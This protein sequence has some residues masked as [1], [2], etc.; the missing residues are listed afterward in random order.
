MKIPKLKTTFS[1]YTDADL[2][3]LAGHVLTS[4]TGNASFPDPIP[5][6]TDLAA[7]ITEYKESLIKAAAL[8][9]LNI[10]DK[11]EKRQVLETLLTQLSFYVIYVAMG[12]VAILTSSGF[13]LTKERETSSLDSPGRID[14]LQGKSTGEL[15]VMTR[16]AVK[17]AVSY[18][19]EYADEPVTESTRWNYV[20]SSRSKYTLQGLTAGKLYFVRV[21]AVGRDAS[22]TYSPVSSSYVL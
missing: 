10:A 7:A 2:E 16:E 5:E 1:R 12:N 4:M 14:L 3:V 21:G 9:R 20:P 13:P 8:G 15:K 6:L 19:F 18:V 17:G 11:N 22:V